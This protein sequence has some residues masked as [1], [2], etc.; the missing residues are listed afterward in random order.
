MIV[1]RIQDLRARLE[2]LVVQHAQQAQ[3]PFKKYFSILINKRR[4]ENSILDVFFELEKEKSALLLSIS[5][6]QTELSTKIY[7]ELTARL[8]RMEGFYFPPQRYIHLLTTKAT[9][10]EKLRRPHQSIQKKKTLDK[11]ALL[12]APENLSVVK[13]AKRDQELA[14]NANPENSEPRSELEDDEES[15]E[16][17]ISNGASSGNPETGHL[18]N[19][20]K[21]C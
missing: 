1:L 12:P 15:E 16:A 14:L 13:V 8:P 19:M 6:T 5:E 9:P 7:N 2:K 18:H 3:G 11:K 10:K 20:R 17:P 4:A 21:P